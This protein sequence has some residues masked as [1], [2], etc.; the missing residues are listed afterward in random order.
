VSH[1]VSDGPS[2]RADARANRERILAAARELFAERGLEVEMREIAQRACVGLGTLYRNIATRDEFISALV[3]EII[4]EVSAA[5]DEAAAV[6]DPLQAVHT[7]LHGAFEVVDRN[8]ALIAA[9]KQAAVAQ[10]RK[11]ELESKASAIWQRAIDAGVIRDGLDASLLS[12]LTGGL[13]DVYLQLRERRPREEARR[14]C[15]SV[16]LHG[17][18]RVKSES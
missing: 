4:T 17:I 16:L 11:G 14:A 2:L 12:D 6:A 18:C 7:L 5:M 3:E 10:H 8:G 15:L 13:F 9:L 1:N